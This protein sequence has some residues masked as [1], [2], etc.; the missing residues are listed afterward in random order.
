MRFK[1]FLY[2]GIIL[3][4]SSVL[5]LA[6]LDLR[7]TTTITQSPDP[8]NAGNTVTFTVSFKTFGGAAD[9]LKITGG[10]DGAG[11]FERIYS[12]I[13]ADSLRTDS[14]SWT[15]T[16][17]S[18]TV[19]FDLDPAHI[20]GD[21]NYSNNRIEKAITVSGGSPGQP[22]L[23]VTGC[24]TEPT[25]YKNGDEVLFRFTIKNIG[26]AQAP[27]PSYADTMIDS[28]L[29]NHIVVPAMG[30]GWTNDYSFS[31]TVK[32]PSTITVTVDSTSVVTESNENDN[33]CKKS[34]KLF[35]I[36]TLHLEKKIN[37]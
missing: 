10:V 34:F 17:G 16:A 36:G 7:F 30:P 4:C 25:T 29:R 9:N 32:I 3:L 5:V 33:S 26:D 14:F 28:T 6:A 18:H 11:I 19:W 35:R 12:H 15:A 27:V 22:N 2:I 1:T 20:C 21:S 13:N 37:K 31:Y 8:A 24:V 23:T